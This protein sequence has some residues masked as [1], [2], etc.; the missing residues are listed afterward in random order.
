M[1][2]V[3][4]DRGD[5]VPELH[6]AAAACGVRSHLIECRHR[7]DLG[8]VK[9]LRWLVD[10]HEIDVLHCHGY[11]EDLYA[12][13]ARTRAKKVTTNHLWKRT[14]PALRFY[15]RVDSWLARR[16][17]RVVA[18]SLEILRELEAKGFKA[19]QLTSIP[20]GVDIARYA[21]TGKQPAGAPRGAAPR[22]VLAAIGSLTEEKGHDH[23][24]G[25]VAR[26]GSDRGITLLIVGDGPRRERLQKLATDLGVADD[27]R[28]LG[29]RNDIPDILAGT[30]IFVLPSL[31]EGLP[32]ALLEAM[33]CERACVATDVGDV[34]RAIETGV[35]GVLVRSADVEALASALERLVAD[36]EL[37]RRLGRAARQRAVE[38]FSAERMTEAY[39]A[40]YDELLAKA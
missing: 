6:T 4:H 7:F 11:R 23:L 27:V 24:L 5:P 1:L 15:A 32:I 8:A 13:A 9:Q 22:T 30:D 28:F 19:P 2:A 36:P 38:R 3:T 31:N 18:V 12:V 37:R 26:L 16:F 20:N 25:A 35:T 10:A 39:C 33:A 29:R 14:T 34:G 17:D 40:L 21:P